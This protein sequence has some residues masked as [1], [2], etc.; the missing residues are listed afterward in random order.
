MNRLA[1]RIISNNKQEHFDESSEDLRGI[2]V[3]VSSTL[4]VAL[5]LIKAV[6]LP[7][8]TACIKAPISIITMENTFSAF[9]LAVGVYLIFKN[10]HKCHN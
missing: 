9:V 5:T 1:L 4:L 3:Y 2:F 6:T 8:M 10:Q 7:K